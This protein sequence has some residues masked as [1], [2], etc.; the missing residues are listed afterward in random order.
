MNWDKYSK[1]F[2]PEEFYSPDVN[3]E[4]MT[5]DF[6][7]ML[8]EARE[9]AGVAFKISSGY[10][11]KERNKAVGGVE[12]SGHLKGMA[13]DLHVDNSRQ[14]FK[15]TKALLDAGFTRIG[16]GRDFIHVDNDKDKAQ[17]VKWRYDK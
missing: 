9:K 13:V 11:T 8:Y 17:E 1:Y 12:S 14:R 16:E 5:E 6:M 15:I 4:K 3:E 7:D 10:R 2:K